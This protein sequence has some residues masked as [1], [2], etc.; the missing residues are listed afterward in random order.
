MFRIN[1]AKG[2]STAMQNAVLLTNS[3]VIVMT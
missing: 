1:H 2:K 3:H